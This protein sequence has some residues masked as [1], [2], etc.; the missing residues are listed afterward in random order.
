MIKY[1]YQIKYNGETLFEGRNVFKPG[2]LLYYINLF[3]I[4]KKKA[5]KQTVRSIYILYVQQMNLAFQL[6]N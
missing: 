1:T 3:S 6:R 2:Q 4:L 5:N